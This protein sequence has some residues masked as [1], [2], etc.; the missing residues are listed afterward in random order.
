MS[1]SFAFDRFAKDHV[2]LYTIFFINVYFD[3]CTPF[4]LMNFSDFRL[5]VVP[6]VS[7]ETYGAAPMNMN[8]GLVL[9]QVLEN[10]H[11]PH[12]RHIYS[13]RLDLKSRKEQRQLT[14]LFFCSTH[15]PIDLHSCST[16]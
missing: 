14:P 6:Q 9:P 1:P 13:I 8:H 2:W 10:P 11:H 3:A 4:L 7:F 15:H 12:I 5:I 16:L